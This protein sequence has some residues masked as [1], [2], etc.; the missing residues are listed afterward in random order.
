MKV[1]TENDNNFG[2]EKIRQYGRQYAFNMEY[3]SL[4]WY[5]IPELV[6]PIKISLIEGC[7]YQ[8][9][10]WT[11][12]SS[13]LS[14]SH[15]FEGFTVATMTWLT[16]M[17]YL[18]HNWPLI[19]STCRKHFPVLSYLRLITGFV[20]GLIRLVSLVKQE[21]LIFAEYLSS[22]RVFIGVRVT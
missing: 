10:Y 19:C 13:C 20:T 1:S 9:S 14:W 4:R 21:L 6:Y 18:C 7:C 15:H 3:T 16:V 11:K 8:G 17:K 2:N 12:G 5:D 22:S